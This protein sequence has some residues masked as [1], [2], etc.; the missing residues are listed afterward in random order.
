MS[1]VSVKLDQFDDP[2]LPVG[3]DEQD[4]FTQRIKAE[5]YAEGFAAGEA[6]ANTQQEN[7]L[8]FLNGVSD[9][10]ATCVDSFPAQIDARICD[11]LRVLLETAFPKISEHGFAVEAVGAIKQAIVVSN[12]P[13]INVNVSPDRVPLLVEMLGR[14]KLSESVKLSPDPSKTKSQA[15][16]EWS[17]AGF[18]MDIDKTCEHL[19][20][21]LERIVQ[22]YNEH[23]GEQVD[24]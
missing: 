1:E 7:D 4:V 10:I 6:R 19:L 15:T 14:E 11:A 3:G 22:N 17:N 8:K 24:V 21:M 13:T 12:K 16:I 2:A 5:A 9:A 18:D 23:M 20:D